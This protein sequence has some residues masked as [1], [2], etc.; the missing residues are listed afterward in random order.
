LRIWHKLTRNPQAT[1]PRHVICF[2][3]ET[4]PKPLGKDLTLHNLKLGTA[5]IVRRPHKNWTHPKFTT[6]KTIDEFWTWL[7][8]QL[9]ERSLTYVF[10]HNIDFD[11]WVVNGF[12]EL[13]K[14]GWNIDSWTVDNN[15]FIVRAR[16][17]HMTLLFLDTLNFVKTD[18]KSIGKAVGLPKLEIDF[19]TCREEELET[20]CR[21][22]TEILLKFVLRWIEF[23][24]K[25]DLGHFQATLASQAFAAYRHRFYTKDIY[26]HAHDKALELERLAYRGGRTECFYLGKIEGQKFYRLDVNSM[27]PYV[28]K[29]HEYP[30]KFVVYHPH[31]DLQGL[32]NA[33]RNYAVIADVEVC[34]DKPAIGIKTERL[35]FPTGQFRAVLTSPE[36]EYLIQNG[37]I[38]NV[39]RYAIYERENL[40]ED[41]VNFFWSLKDTAREQDNGFEYAIAKL[42][43]NS[44]YGKWGQKRQVIKI[45]EEKTQIPNGF[46]H[47][48]SS[49]TGKEFKMWVI[50]G[51]AFEQVAEEEAYNSFPAIS[52]FITAYARTYLWSLIERA[53]AKHCYYCDTDSL[54]VDQEGFDNLRDM[55][56]D[57]RIGALRLQGE[58]DYLEIRGL[59]DYTFGDEVRHKG[60]SP[61]AEQAE[62]NVFTQ[63][64]FLKTKSLIRLGEIK[65]AAVRKITKVLTHEYKKG[66]VNP[67]GWITP[68]EMKA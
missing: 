35:I 23:V 19:R 28:M 41:Y 39:S 66:N 9:K 17:S 44:L 25:Y 60:I 1:V 49:V 5:C 12:S 13:R 58:A 24:E 56:D 37:K 54:I 2:D 32:Y 55:I 29:E 36:L 26:I 14:R 65:G 15:R 31:P 34:T 27:Y 52:A 4:E 51:T 7:D 63:D 20:Y 3:C 48:F 40:F 50:D 33:L 8:R 16:K 18:L 61:N 45:I 67:D 46:Y 68:Y 57:S 47:G 6:F 21:R 38:L 11:F 53:G 42:F 43:L 22:D 64:Q 30:C 62:D 10:A 59:K